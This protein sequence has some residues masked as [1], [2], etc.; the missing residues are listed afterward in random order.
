MKK[1]TSVNASL[2]DIYIY[3]YYY[4]H[5]I[6]MIYMQLQDYWI[7][8][9]GGEHL[10]KTILNLHSLVYYGVYVPYYQILFENIGYLNFVTLSD[11][12]IPHHLERI[13]LYIYIIIDMIWKQKSIN[14]A[15]NSAK[16]RLNR[17]PIPYDENKYNRKICRILN[18]LSNSL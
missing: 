2:S 11:F 17:I 4:L 10:C 16:L 12:I 1:T 18:K 15:M 9:L 8:Y 5:F 7:S 14:S 3:I 13:N 6:F